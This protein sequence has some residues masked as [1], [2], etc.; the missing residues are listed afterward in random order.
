MVKYIFEQG[1]RDSFT[2]LTS[3]QAATYITAITGNTHLGW[4]AAGNKL[5]PLSIKDYLH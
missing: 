2:F 3:A 5:E 4:D 1:I